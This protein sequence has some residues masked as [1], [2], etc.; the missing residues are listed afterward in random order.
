MAAGHRFAEKPP[1]DGGWINGGFFVAEPSIL[2]YI[3]DDAT[4]FE[5][6]TAG[7]PLR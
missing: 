4:I 2:D 5:Q 6:V 3:D 1:E 7:T